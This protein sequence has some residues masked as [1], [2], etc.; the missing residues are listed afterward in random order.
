MSSGSDR[1]GRRYRYGAYTGGPDP[2]AP[3]YDVRAAVDE[4]GD[5]VLAGESLREALRD[6]L[7]RGTD[8]RRGLDD[9][10]ARARRRRQQLQRSGRLDGALTRARALLDQALATERDALSERDA[11]AGPEGDP[12]TDFARA[13]LDSLPDSTASAVRELSDY[14][15]TSPQAQQLYN[16]ILGELGQQVLDQQLAGLSSMLSEGGISPAQAAELR[17]LLTDLT[18]LLDKHARG[19]DTD[20]DFADFMAKHGHQLDGDPQ[21]IEELLDLLARQAAASQRLLNSLRPEQ[22]AELADLMSQAMAQAGLQDE[23]SRFSAALRGLR[24]EI[25]RPGRAQ[26]SGEPGLDYTGAT[27]VLGELADLDDVLDQLARD[28]GELGH[29]LDDVDV[30]AV[31]RTLGRRAA[32]ELR[33]LVDLERALRQQGWVSS[34]PDGLT[35]S[36]KAL[37]RLG[38]TAL[39]RVFAQLSSQ[40]RGQHDV[41]EAGAAG[42]LTGSSRGWQL[43]DTQPI[44]V[45]RTVSNAIRRTAGTA[46]TGPRGAVA[47]TVD[48]FEVAETERRTGA[49]VALCVDLS[50]S[51]LAEGRWGPMKQTALALAHLA[52][53]QYPQ[54]S[55]QIIGFGR[56]AMTLS[57]TELAGIEPAY[58]QGTNL[59]HAL[60]LA[61]RHLRRHPSGDPVVLV[62]TDGEPT[63]HLDIDGEAWF[64]WPPM[65]ETIRATVREVDTL[66]RYGAVL[67]IVMLGEDAGLRRFVDA[68]A[69]RCGGRVLTPELGNLGAYVIDDYV[70]SRRGR[71]S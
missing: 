43:G 38:E 67:N 22:R 28:P 2:L 18:E 50:Y 15:W 1:H 23:M 61:G 70:R 3:P 44:D 65:P 26:V 39:R 49:S 46:T 8:G 64:S 21:N 37:R 32:D 25:G 68:V 6:L 29:T 35:L 42:E 13:R 20:Q 41:A 63:A 58:E 30:D 56:Y 71:R 14:E 40:G 48:D 45:V 51:M 31:E 52:A 57:A 9:L 60:T 33:Q 54:D 62:V 69:R 12:M 7:R 55:L 24:P 11:A 19:E 53:T 66:T 47:L 16:Q 17:E 59:A 27:G 10:Y 34:G 5:R 36:P 4:V